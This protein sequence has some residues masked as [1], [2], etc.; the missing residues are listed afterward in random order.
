[1]GPLK[2][3]STTAT[4]PK[5]ET[6][7]LQVPPVD[8]FI[9][10]ATVGTTGRVWILPFQALS[11]EYSAIPIFVGSSEMSTAANTRDFLALHAPDELADLRDEFQ[12]FI[13]TPHGEWLNA[14]HRMLID[15][16]GC[17]H[18][19]CPLQR[20]PR[21]PEYPPPSQVSTPTITPDH[22]YYR[23]HF[24]PGSYAAPTHHP[25]RSSI[26]EVEQDISSLT[27]YMNA[28][29]TLARQLSGKHLFAATLGAEYRTPYYSCMQM[30]GELGVPGHFLAMIHHG[31]GIHMLIG[32]GFT[33]GRQHDLT[34]DQESLRR[35]AD[36]MFEKVV[37]LYK[38]D[39]PL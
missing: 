27:H 13:R 5:P 36:K 3:P 7:P 16:D 10:S 12:K 21:P 38:E 25:E 28:Y 18:L 4:G 30:C 23:R 14:T 22:W 11:V 9:Q 20:T 37:T 39:F 17:A 35:M 29:D 31:I 33:F 34:S 1:M 32:Q 19:M 8:E 15:P 6:G 26:N 2:I 24:N